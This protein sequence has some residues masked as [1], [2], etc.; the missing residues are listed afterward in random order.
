MVRGSELLEPSLGVLHS[1]QTDFDWERHGRAEPVDPLVGRDHGDPMIG[2]AGDDLLAQQG[3]TSALD[4]LELGIDLVGSVEV[5][6][7]RGHVVEF[8]EGDVPV[9]GLDSAVVSLVATP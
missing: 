9:R 2:G 3:T 1:E 4:H 7:E 8:A 5:D 6:I